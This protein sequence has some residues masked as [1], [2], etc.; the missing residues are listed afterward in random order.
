VL[1]IWVYRARLLR[2]EPDLAA[3]W[4]IGYAMKMLSPAQAEAMADWALTVPLPATAGSTGAA[5][6]STAHPA[7]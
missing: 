4:F 7:H 3:D 5:A 2:G 1:G 6:V